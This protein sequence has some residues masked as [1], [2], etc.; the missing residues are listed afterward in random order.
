MA[1][2]YRVELLSPWGEHFEVR[3]VDSIPSAMAIAQDM[4]EYHAGDNG[5]EVTIA[6]E[7]TEEG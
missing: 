1:E 6:I 4:L 7:F 5:W 3:H 2:Q